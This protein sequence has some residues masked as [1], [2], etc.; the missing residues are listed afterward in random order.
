MSLVLSSPWGIPYN[1]FVLHCDQKL[2]YLWW[3]GIKL[4]KKKIWE[5][6]T[7]LKWKSPEIDFNYGIALGHQQIKNRFLMLSDWKMINL[8]SNFNMFICQELMQWDRENVLRNFLHWR[9]IFYFSFCNSNENSFLQMISFNLQAVQ[10]CLFKKVQ[11]LV[12]KMYS[13]LWLQLC[14]SMPWFWFLDCNTLFVI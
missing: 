12:I 2:P 7:Q 11:S 1:I 14:F 9:L 10:Y 8:L 3:W 13:S 4:K 5:I 6:Q